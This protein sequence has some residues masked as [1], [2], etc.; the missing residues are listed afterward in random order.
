MRQQ[1]PDWICLT[2]PQYTFLCWEV[3]LAS[4]IGARYVLGSNRLS[5]GGNKVMLAHPIDVLE[6]SGSVTPISRFCDYNGFKSVQ[7]STPS[8][9]E[10][11]S[12][13]DSETFQRERSMAET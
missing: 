1:L 6:S 13:F 9:L 8:A 4:L 2:S 11:R 10:R 3:D 7:G 12:M 5:S